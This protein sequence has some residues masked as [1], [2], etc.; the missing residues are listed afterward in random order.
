M[1]KGLLPGYRELIQ[2]AQK[3]RNGAA[4][5]IIA[6]KLMDTIEQ[7]D[8]IISAHEKQAEIAGYPCEWPNGKPIE[9]IVGKT[10]KTKSGQDVKIIAYCPELKCP[11]VGILD[12]SVEQ[13]SKE[14]HFLDIPESI[15]DLILE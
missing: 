13:W 4:L 9:M 14:G 1:R 7:M 8:A 11:I 5:G 2:G 15:V 12:G 3:E 10:V 6:D